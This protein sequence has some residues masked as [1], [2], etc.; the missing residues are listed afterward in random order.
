MT[1]MCG[2]LPTAL[3]ALI[4]ASC[5]T[6][7]VPTQPQVEVAPQAATVLPSEFEPLIGHVRSRAALWREG[8]PIN[9]LVLDD[10]QT[11]LNPI[12]I[13][14]ER[15]PPVVIVDLDSAGAEPARLPDIAQSATPGWI[16]ALDALRREDVSIIW[17]TNYSAH[18]TQAVV[19]RLAA[20]GLDP[21]GGDRLMTLRPGADRKQLLRRDIAQSSCVLAVVGDTRGDADEAY[22]YL[23]SADA[24]LPIDSNWGAG[25]FLLPAPLS[26]AGAK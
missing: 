20:T 4:L 23:R 17:V 16:A 6:S 15:R 26:H 11:V 24:V 8:A 13:G 12:A 19:Q 2:A 14:C 1:R 7:A 25:W 21:L 22:D 10:R 3:A 18:D 5:A 9:S